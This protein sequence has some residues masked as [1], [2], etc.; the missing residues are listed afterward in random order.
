MCVW[1]SSLEANFS[2]VPNKKSPG[3]RTRSGFCS[4]IRFTIR[5]KKRAPL[6]GPACKSEIRAIFNECFPIFDNAIKFLERMIA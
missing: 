5:L 3:I 4:L 2:A 6:N 1:C